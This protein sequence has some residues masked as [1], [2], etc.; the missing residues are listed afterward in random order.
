M[1]PYS[2]SERVSGHIQR[3]LSELLTRQIKDPRLD[4]VVISSVK[5]SR[6]LKSARI[7]YAVSGEK[8]S[9]EDAAKGF[10]SAT[11]FVK[12]ELARELGLRYMPE[13]TFFYDDTFDYA[14]N[15]ERILRSLKNKN[16]NH[17]STAE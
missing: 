5:L 17:Q 4:T 16:G 15:V 13:L 11:G 10:K 6:D 14:A 2:R 9:R 8:K 7:Y 12:R 3:I 1:K